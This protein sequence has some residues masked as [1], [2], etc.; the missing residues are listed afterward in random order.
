MLFAMWPQPVKVWIN[1][2]YDEVG[3]DLDSDSA[4]PGT[5]NLGF[6]GERK[7]EKL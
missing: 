2:I 3:A 5:I 1:R 6:V 4:R 7:K